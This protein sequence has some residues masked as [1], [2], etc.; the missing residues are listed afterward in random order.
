MVA[1]VYQWSFFLQWTQLFCL[2]EK[3]AGV[4][5]ILLHCF[6]YLP[7]FLIS[8][9][10]LRAFNEIYHLHT[11]VQKISAI[12]YWHPWFLNFPWL[13]RY[14]ILTWNAWRIYWRRGNFRRF[15]AIPV[16]AIKIIKVWKSLWNRRVWLGSGI[17][18]RNI[19]TCN[20]R[21]CGCVCARLG[22]RARV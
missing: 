4:F 6:T 13:H 20:P 3:R 22:A 10:H 19:E 1:I 2:R 17:M 12:F 11:L 14:N 9:G 18:L 21:K 7:E 8:R 16:T 15:S 5:S